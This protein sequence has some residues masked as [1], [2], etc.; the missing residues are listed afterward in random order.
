MGEVINIVMAMV[1]AASLQVARAS[2]TSIECE[3]LRA[4]ALPYRYEK[5]PVPLSVSRVTTLH[6][7]DWPFETMRRALTRLGSDTFSDFEVA[8]KSRAPFECS[9]PTYGGQPFALNDMP[10]ADEFIHCEVARAGIGQGGQQALFYFRCSAESGF[11]GGTLTTF[12]L[13]DDSWEFDEGTFEMPAG[14]WIP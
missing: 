9:G 2:D 1:A 5:A 6:V 7:I 11:M 14:E 4:S 3:L 12:K 13:Q 10:A 8:N